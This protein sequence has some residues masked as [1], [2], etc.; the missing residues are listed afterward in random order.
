M[1]EGP[2]QVLLH[3]YEKMKNLQITEYEE[4]EEKIWKLSSYIKVITK[5]VQ[6]HKYQF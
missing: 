1:E 5:C 6:K 4:K 3:L 2:Q